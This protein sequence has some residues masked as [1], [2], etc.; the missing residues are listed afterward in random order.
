MTQPLPVRGHQRPESQCM[1]REEQIMVDRRLQEWPRSQAPTGFESGRLINDST[2]LL[3][4][5][6]WRHYCCRAGIST[7][8]RGSS[9]IPSAATAVVSSAGR[10]MLAGPRASLASFDRRLDAA[11]VRHLEQPRADRDRRQFP[12]RETVHQTLE[13]QVG[14]IDARQPRVA[15]TT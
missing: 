9:G 1:W 3:A 15:D 13:R 12:G 14:E 2:E 4:N 8:V 11:D 7:A 6:G 10:R 5:M